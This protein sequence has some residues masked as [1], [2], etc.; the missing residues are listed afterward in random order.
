MSAGLGANPGPAHQHAL[1]RE[2]FPGWG[3]FFMLEHWA[4]TW[5]WLV[6]FSRSGSSMNEPSNPG[7]WGSSDL[8]CVC[9]PRGPHYRIGLISVFDCGFG[10]LVAVLSGVPPSVA[11]ER[12][13]FPRWSD[14]VG[15]LGQFAGGCN[16][17]SSLIRQF[18]L[19]FWVGDLLDHSTFPC[20]NLRI[21]ELL[22]LPFALVGPSRL[23]GPFPYRD[24]APL[25]CTTRGTA[26]PPVTPVQE[27]SP[28]PLHTTR[29]SPPPG[30]H[31]PNPIFAFWGPKPC[32]YRSVASPLGPGRRSWLLRASRGYQ[33]H[34][35]LDLELYRVL[36]TDCS[37][38]VLL[39]V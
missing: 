5:S 4:G 25:G 16:V 12:G 21:Y 9:C 19:G 20:T 6:L 8:E 35:P 7:Y 32:R 14:L 17:L 24:F 26:K 1:V 10:V 31:R 29:S 37:S 23:S 22:I 39:A 34:F 15:I 30:V 3:S 13:E 36:Y 11:M 28:V 2:S 27:S 38:R 18:V 33:Q